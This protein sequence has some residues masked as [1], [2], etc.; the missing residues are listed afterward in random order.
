MKRT[1]KRNKWKKRHQTRNRYFYGNDRVRGGGGVIMNNSKYGYFHNQEQ[2]PVYFYGGSDEVIN[3]VVAVVP[4]ATTQQQIEQNV[5]NERK[6]DSHIFQDMFKLTEGITSNFIQ[7]VGTNL[8]VDV[9]NPQQL[10]S[11]FDSLNTFISDPKNTAKLKEMISN[12][13]AIGKDILKAASPFIDPLVDKTIEEGKIA[14]SKIGT[15][16]I[17][18]GLNTAEE[19]PG[20]GV[21]IGTLRSLSNA[22]EAIAAATNAFSEITTH[23]SDT[24]NETSKNFKRIQSEKDAILKNT[25]D[26]IKNFTQPIQIPSAVSIKP[27]VK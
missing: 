24:I 22:G 9:S 12:S 11:L 19:I 21:L 5:I 27:S 17:K 3:P 7:N 16:A 14:A 6:S 4:E 8:G 15:S 25:N 10:N 20:V 13:A 26:S 23:T 1:H 18:I 2:N